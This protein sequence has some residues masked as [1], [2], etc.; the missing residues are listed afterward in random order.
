[1]T[2]LIGWWENT[3]VQ[4]PNTS[5]SKM[6]GQLKIECMKRVLIH[7]ALLAVIASP[8]EGNAAQLFLSWADNSKDEEGFRIERKK[9]T[10]GKFEEIAIVGPNVT[11]YTDA[12]AQVGATYCYRVRAFNPVGNSAYTQE[13]CATAGPKE[14]SKSR[15]IMG[16]YE[17]R[18]PTSLYSQP[19]E[20][21]QQVAAIRAGMKVDVV[22]IQGDWLEIGPKQGRPP[23]FIRR[24]SSVPREGANGVAII[25]VSSRGFRGLFSRRPKTSILSVDGKEVAK[26]NIVEVSAGPHVIGIEC[27]G[28]P[29]RFSSRKIR[30]TFNYDLPAKGGHTYQIN[31]ELVGGMC[32]L[33]IDERNAKNHLRTIPD[34]RDSLRVSR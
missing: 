21:S 16:S 29:R 17:V 18:R 31:A 3:F 24:D 5:L 15:S 28:A 12:S 25:K 1:M 22:G 14:P 34:R 11:S 8:Y 9:S 32:K 10:H 30:D 33:W 2:R 6:W 19:N 20:D 7:L 13:I 23:G 27:I 4:W 26:S